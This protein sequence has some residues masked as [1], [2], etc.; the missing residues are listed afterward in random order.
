M[1]DKLYLIR[2]ILETDE[3]TDIKI[4]SILESAKE[5]PD[6]ENIY[7]IDERVAKRK[8]IAIEVNVCTEQTEIVAELE[9]ISCTGAFIKM[10]KKIDQDKNISIIFTDSSG[11]KFT[12]AAKVMRVNHHGIGVEVDT[13]SLSGDG[14]F[15]KFLDTL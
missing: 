3:D 14:D 12:F 5:N 10:E 8:K 11:K 2:Q 7:R 13:I 4:L 9:D 15:T 6:T 1:I